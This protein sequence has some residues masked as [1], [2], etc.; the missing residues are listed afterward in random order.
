M[1]AERHAQILQRSYYANVLVGSKLDDKLC[2][3][4]C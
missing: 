1:V 3:E 4:E 2:E